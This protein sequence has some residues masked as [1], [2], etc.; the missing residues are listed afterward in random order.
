MNIVTG[1]F[2]ILNAAGFFAMG[3]DK[4][5]AVRGFWRIPER[6]LFGIALLGGAPGSILGMYCFRHKTRHRTFTLGMPLILFFQVVIYFL[7]K[8]M[9]L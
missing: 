1:Y 5:K 9:I 6:V 4:L 2:M 7:I 8:G 3:L